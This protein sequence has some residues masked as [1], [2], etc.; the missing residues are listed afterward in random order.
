MS[1]LVIAFMVVIGVGLAAGVSFA[2]YAALPNDM[3]D[4][5]SHHG[6][7]AGLGTSA[8]ID[9][10]AGATPIGTPTHLQGQTA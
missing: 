7:Y 10:A 3:L 8:T 5:A 2:L 9:G 1:M 6:R 4:L